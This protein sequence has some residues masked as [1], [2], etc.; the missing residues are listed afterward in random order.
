VPERGARAS[1]DL[2]AF[3]A[4]VAHEIRTPLT[5]VAA[6]VEIALR[7]DRTAA[8]YRATLRQIAAGI[9]E[10]V[11]ISGDLTLFSDAA[12][13]DADAPAAAL[14]AV[15]SRVRAKYAGR[16]DVVI[17]DG[18]ADASVTGDHDRLARA[19]AAVIEHAL[20]HRRGRPTLRVDA[21][22]T[23]DGVALVI[24]AGPSGFWPRA[25]C[26]L[27]REPDDP[28]T[29]LRLRT[30][31]RILQQCG[32]VLRLAAAPDPAAEAVHIDLHRRP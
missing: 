4:A 3:A 2:D 8:E 5:A 19:I 10:L 24:S 29:P 31:R 17:G 13:E 25:W 27:E 20:R 7:R 28:A 26:A 22:P 30:A 9:A 21:I 15:V 32:G 6:E 12:A 11:D 23:P 16:D 18:L 14:A 1:E